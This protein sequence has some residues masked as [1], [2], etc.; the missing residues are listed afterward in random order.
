MSNFIL[1]ELF[2][3]KA[4]VYQTRPVRAMKYQEGM[5]NGWMLY[6]SNKSNIYAGIKF[7][8]TKEEAMRYVEANNPEYININGKLIEDTVQYDFI[9]PVMYRKY[10]EGEKRLGVDMG[11]KGFTFVSDESE[12]YDFYILEENTW[13]IL[14][15]EGNIRVWEQDFLDFGSSTFFGEPEEFVYERSMVSG[16]EEYIKATV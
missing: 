5:E 10:I 8:D 4:K 11:I 15:A 1:N 16:K 14:D 9:K 13:I 3:Q 7:F 2:E 12:I 6:M